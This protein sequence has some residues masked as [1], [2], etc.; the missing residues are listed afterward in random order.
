M[1]ET[2]PE[3]PVCRVR[4]EEGHMLDAKDGSRLGRVSWMK[5]LRRGDPRLRTKGRDRSSHNGG[6][7]AALAA[8]SPPHG[9]RKVRAGATA[10]LS[11]HTD[12]P[13]RVHKYSLILK[14]TCYNGS[15][16]A[17]GRSSSRRKPLLRYL[18]KRG[19]NMKL[20]DRQVV[21]KFAIGFGVVLVCSRSWARSIVGI[22]SISSAI[23]WPPR[24]SRVS[25]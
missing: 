5:A 18:L 16:R 25:G 7:R 10:A 23:G 11:L 24:D 1:N 6:A 2:A 3:C 15:L 13:V 12:A 8:G 20:K 17:T 14:D 4:M 21:L 19:F 22:R 9:E